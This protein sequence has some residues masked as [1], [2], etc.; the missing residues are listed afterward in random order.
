MITFILS[1]STIMAIYYWMNRVVLTDPR[2]VDPAAIAPKK[3]SSKPALWESLQILFSSRHLMFIAVIVIAYGISIN[4]IE[5]VWKSQVKHYYDVTTATASAAKSGM[6]QFYSNTNTATGLLSIVLMLFVSGQA[7]RGLGWTFAALIT[8]VAILVLG[9]VFFGVSLALQLGFSPEFLS[10]VGN[11]L[12]FTIVVGAAQNAISKAAKYSLFDPTKEKAYFPL[13]DDGRTKGKGAVDV[14]G[15]RLGKAGG[16]FVQQFIIMLFGSVAAGL[17]GL[18]VIVF[19]AV[20][21]WI[22]A[23]CAIGSRLKDYEK[24]LESTP[25]K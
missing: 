24:K 1:T 8:P 21:G 9:F 20:G 3:K 5:I 2:L 11:P 12:F 10:S 25:V 14:I 15:A 19:L 18:A 13:D 4:L 6:Q 16:A 7:E 17:S 23:T 22:A